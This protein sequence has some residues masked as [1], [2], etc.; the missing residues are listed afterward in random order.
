MGASLEHLVSIFDRI[1][2]GTVTVWHGGFIYSAEWYTGPQVRLVN[3]LRRDPETCKRYPVEPEGFRSMIA[4][5]GNTVCVIDASDSSY[6]GSAGVKLGRSWPTPEE[7]ERD[8]HYE[9]FVA[10]GSAINFAVEADGLEH[11]GRV[12]CFDNLQNAVA[13]KIQR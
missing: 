7:V 5:L 1:S 4:K 12:A 13:W 3:L 8:R 9:T 2:N 6:V 10:L 11:K